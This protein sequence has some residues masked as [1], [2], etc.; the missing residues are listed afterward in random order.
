MTRYALRQNKDTGKWF[1]VELPDAWHLTKR[2]LSSAQA[3]DIWTRAAEGQDKGKIA[4]D[5]GVVI[6]T[7]NNIADGRSHGLAVARASQRFHRH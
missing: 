5:F 3:E 6:G 4:E 7:V 2:K 1:R